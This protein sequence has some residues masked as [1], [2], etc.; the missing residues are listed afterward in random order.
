MTK[1]QKALDRLCAA[2]TPADIRWSELKSALER[3]GYVELSGR[4][5][6]KKFHHREK[7]LIISC[8]R[9]HPSPYVDK[10]CVADVVAHLRDN[11]L[12]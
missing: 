2:P 10:G 3:L 4:G 6:R 5:S 8:H 11:R 1:H 9:P 7:G 12:I